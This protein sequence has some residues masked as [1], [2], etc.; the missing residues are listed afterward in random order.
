MRRIKYGRRL[1]P[2]ANHSLLHPLFGLI[3]PPFSF[4][5]FLLSVFSIFSI[6]LSSFR[7][8]PQ[9]REKLQLGR[10][11]LISRGTHGGPSSA[12]FLLLLL[13]SFYFPLLFVNERGTL[14]V[15][16]EISRRFIT[17]TRNLCRITLAR[18][19]Y[20][21]EEFRS[22]ARSFMEHANSIPST[23]DRSRHAVTLRYHRVAQEI[24]YLSGQFP[25]NRALFSH[26]PP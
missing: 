12:I 14:T 11:L 19:I 20:G 7:R 1:G 10:I 22:S 18:E 5:L 8:V 26:G 25:T 13:S 24:S 17:A 9:T 23:R 3:K 4:L 6:F 15:G 2:A 21:E 16:R